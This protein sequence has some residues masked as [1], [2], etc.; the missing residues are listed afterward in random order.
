MDIIIFI[1]HCM[2][3]MLWFRLVG[4]TR[5]AFQIC[6]ARGLLPCDARNFATQVNCRVCAIFSAAILNLANSFSAGNAMNIMH[7]RIRKPHIP[8]AD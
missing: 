6:L 2:V 7:T 8:T 1:D 5:A 3:S 4:D